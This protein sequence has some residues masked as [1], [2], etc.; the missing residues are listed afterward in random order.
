MTTNVIPAGLFF[1]PTF[2]TP[3]NPAT[4]RTAGR[5]DRPEAPPVTPVFILLVVVASSTSLV[6]P[7][8]G[9]N[10]LIPLLLLSPANPLRWA[11]LGTP[12]CPP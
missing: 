6:P 4:T 7:R 2:D 9:E 10:S 11:S 5:S 1:D 3:Q 8:M 12:Y